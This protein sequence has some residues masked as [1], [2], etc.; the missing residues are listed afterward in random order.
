MEIL[1]RRSEWQCKARADY[2]LYTQKNTL[3]RPL[4]LLIKIYNNFQI[5]ERRAQSVGRFYLILSTKLLANCLETDARLPK[6][7][8]IRMWYERRGI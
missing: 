3:L 7:C 5:F 8:P 6:C 1:S 4:L 2:I